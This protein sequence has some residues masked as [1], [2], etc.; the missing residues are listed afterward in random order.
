MHRLKIF[1]LIAF[2]ACLSATPAFAHAFLERAVPGVGLTVAASP[3]E[4]TLI[5]T[6]N[7]VLAFSGVHVTTTKGRSVSSDK[8]TRDRTKPNVLHVRLRQR[9]R[10]GTYIVHWH[11]VS[12]DTHRTSGTYQ[13]TVAP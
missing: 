11:V 10:P 3:R 9:L 2:C 13:F 8:P 7:V 5:F 1:F 12:V 6:Q 4:L